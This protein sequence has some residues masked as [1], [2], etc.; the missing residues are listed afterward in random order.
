MEKGTL[1]DTFKR[2]QNHS[3]K[4]LFGIYKGHYPECGTG[5]A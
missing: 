1:L 3:L 4:T 5:F 2:N